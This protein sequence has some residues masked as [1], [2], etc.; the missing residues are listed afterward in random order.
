MKKTSAILGATVAMLMLPAMSQADVKVYGKIH[1]SA[2][3]IDTGAGTGHGV[4]SNSTRVGFKGSEDLNYGLKAIWKIENELN[5]AIKD[6]EFSSRDRYLGLNYG[7]STLVGG[8]FNTPFKTLGGKSDAFDDTIADHRGI[9]GMDY[10]SGFKKFDDRAPNAVM[11]INNSV[12][13]L[14]FRLMRSAGSPNAT[15]GDTTPLTS[16]SIM[17]KTSQ[18]LVGAAY[19]DK[20]EFSTSGVRLIAGV[21]FGGTRIT[22]IYEQLDFGDTDSAARPGWDRSAMGINAVHQMGATTLKVQARIA[23]DLESQTD[24]GGKMYAAGVSHKLAKPFEIYGMVAYL[25]NDSN[26]MYTLTGSG[27]GDKYNPTVAGE[28]VTGVS[29]GGIYKF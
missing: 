22:G 26:A 18:L 14:E 7:K 10:G 17:Y 12:A 11:Y 8:Y 19:E 2:D 21:A 3:A 25:D 13:G 28:A 16:T 27:H 6:K 24:T 5:I 23:N 15:V 4:S 1:M 20:E 29:F 9:M